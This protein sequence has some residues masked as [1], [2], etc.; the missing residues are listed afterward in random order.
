MML[1]IRRTIGGQQQSEASAD[2]FTF[3][4]SGV[5]TQT[6]D[7]ANFSLTNFK[8]Q[9]DAAAF[10][11]MRAN[12]PRMHFCMWIKDECIPL[13]YIGASSYLRFI[14]SSVAFQGR[15]IARMKVNSGYVQRQLQHFKDAFLHIHQTL[16][17]TV[18][19]FTRTE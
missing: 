12:L 14:F 1:L 10:I 8:C 18:A 5:F 3:E 2:H 4:Y 16:I 15:Q 17:R 11:W 19:N 6:G 9:V 13:I 7:N